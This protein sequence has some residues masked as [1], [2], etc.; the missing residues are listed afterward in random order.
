MRQTMIGSMDA[1]DAE[2]V[3]LE[4]HPL[5]IV[6]ERPFEALKDVFSR[7]WSVAY[8][9]RAAPGHSQ[10]DRI[11]LDDVRMINSAMGARSP[12]GDWRGLIGR[13]PLPELVAVDPSWDAV[14][15]TNENWQQQRV[16]ERVA[17]LL[18]AVMGRPGIGP[19]RASKVLHLKRPALIPVCDSRLLRVLGI[20][21]TQDDAILTVLRHLRGE[22]GRLEVQLKVLQERLAGKGLQRPL[23]RI[24]EVLVWGSTEP[25]FRGGLGSARRD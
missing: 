2:E 22:G 18:S 21:Q 7:S 17:A 1:A 10:T 13:N 23:I 12:H 11:V 6:I 3:A 5:P 14:L 4:V 9:G 20:A 8:D 19:A 24:L 16:E 25:A 15:M